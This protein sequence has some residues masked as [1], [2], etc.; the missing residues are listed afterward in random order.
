MCYFILVTFPLN[1]I[2]LI[3][4]VMEFILLYYLPF[5]YMFRE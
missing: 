2:H 4:V 3:S 5:V 1:Q